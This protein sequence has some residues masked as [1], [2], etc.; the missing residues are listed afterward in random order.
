MSHH[1]EYY[2][3][4]SGS[5]YIYR[6]YRYH[7]Q[8]NIGYSWQ[9]FSSAFLGSRMRGDCMFLESVIIPLGYESTA[10]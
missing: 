3:H 8:C 1:A 2:S 10:N 9:Q 7:I 6:Q 5:S 4:T